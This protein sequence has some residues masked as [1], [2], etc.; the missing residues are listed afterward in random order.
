[1]P[2][3]HL[4]ELRHDELGLSLELVIV[5]LGLLRLRQ[6]LHHAA[7]RLLQLRQQVHC[8]KGTVA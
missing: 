2:R 5:L 8:L 3:G 6:A 4:L 7:L 1:M